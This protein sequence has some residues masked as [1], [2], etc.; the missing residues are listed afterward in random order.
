MAQ[1]ED[2]CVLRKMGFPYGSAGKEF[3]CNARDLGSK[4]PLEKGKAAHSSILKYM[5]VTEIWGH[6]KPIS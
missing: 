6:A 2:E 1:V 5:L 4:D 3:A